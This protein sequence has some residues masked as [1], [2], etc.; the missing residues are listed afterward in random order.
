MIACKVNN[1]SKE[2]LFA[3]LCVTTN[4]KSRNLQLKHVVRSIRTIEYAKRLYNKEFAR[5]LTLQ[6]LI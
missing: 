1:E 5:E 3:S 2:M 4:N 6:L